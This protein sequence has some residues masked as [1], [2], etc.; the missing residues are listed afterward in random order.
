MAGGFPLFTNAMFHKLGVD[1]ASSPLGFIAVALTPILVVFYSLGGELGQGE[2]DRGGHLSDQYL[3]LKLLAHGMDCYRFMSSFIM[4]RTIF[5]YV[6][7]F[8]CYQ[9]ANPMR[10]KGES[11]I[12]Q[13]GHHSFNKVF[14][15]F[16]NSYIYTIN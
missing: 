3:L 16:F 11:Q 10:I 15:S 12:S 13:R 7:R 14:I 6:N 1:W 8:L 2:S 5:N 9:D 4:L